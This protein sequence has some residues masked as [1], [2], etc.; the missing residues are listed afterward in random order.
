MSESMNL[1]PEPT[2]EKYVISEELEVEVLEIARNAIRKKISIELQ[3]LK[4]EYK[5]DNYSNYVDLVKFR[6]KSLSDI[7]L[8]IEKHN[9]ISKQI[10]STTDVYCPDYSFSDASWRE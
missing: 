6:K 10:R 7:E 9:N 2:N 8:F 4:A 3:K 1:V 5:H